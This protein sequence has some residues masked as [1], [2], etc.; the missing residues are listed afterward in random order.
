MH[1]KGNM[2]LIGHFAHLPVAVVR[3]VPDDARRQGNAHSA[4]PFIL[5]V[6]T[7]HIVKHILFRIVMGHLKFRRE[8]CG[9]GEAPAVYAAYSDILHGLGHIIAET[10]A[11]MAVHIVQ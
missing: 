2:H 6:Q 4:V 3:V 1:G 11:G 8:I 10:R 9:I 7:P 5:F